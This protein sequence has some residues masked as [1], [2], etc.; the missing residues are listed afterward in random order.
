MKT[1]QPDLAVRVQIPPGEECKAGWLVPSREVA[2]ALALMAC[3][4]NQDDFFFLPLTYH[5]YVVL[6]NFRGHYHAFVFVHSPT[7]QKASL[8][9]LPTTSSSPVEFFSFHLVTFGGFY[10]CVCLSYSKNE[11]IIKCLNS[12]V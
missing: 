7:L 10:W 1:W 3:F 8:I 2:E 12:L 4:L 9:L 11:I 6:W 5:W